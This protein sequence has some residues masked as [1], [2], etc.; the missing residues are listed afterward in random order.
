MK[1]F[2][3]LR[4]MNLFGKKHGRS[5]ERYYLQYLHSRNALENL[6]RGTAK[7]LTKAGKP[8]KVQLKSIWIDGT[9]QAVATTV[10]GTR[11]QCELAD[12]LFILEEKDHHGKTIKETGLLLQAKVSRRNNKIP[13]GASTKKERDLLEEMDRNKKIALYRGTGGTTTSQIGTSPYILS[14]TLAGLEDCARY[15]LMP[16]EPMWQGLPQRYAPYQVGWPASRSKAYLQ[17]PVSILRAVQDM[18]ISRT[19]GR[20]I[21]H[22]SQCEWSRMV[23]DLRQ[24]YSGVNMKGFGGQPRVSSSGFVILAT[25]TYATS[26]S[27]RRLVERVLPPNDTHDKLPND[28]EGPA[29]SILHLTIQYL[30]EREQTE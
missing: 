6:A 4:W 25:E 2:G 23:D 19:V 8:C 14:R 28:G 27:T 22:R 29:I 11:V 30:N 16:L 12:L 13:E 3:W 1:P 24:G 10:S 26:S 18:V 7:V 20:Q 17:S 21:L 15:L 9:P 5:L